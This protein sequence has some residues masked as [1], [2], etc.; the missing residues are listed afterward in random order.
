MIYYK[1]LCN[2]KFDDKYNG[3]SI[4]IENHDGYEKYFSNALKNY[5]LDLPKLKICVPIV[6][7][8]SEMLVTPR[9]S[10]CFDLL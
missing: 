6:I 8:A 1:I 3:D 7:K 9:I 10:E 2:N 5:Q 4:E